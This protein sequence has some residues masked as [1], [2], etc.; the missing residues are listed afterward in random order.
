MHDDS[1]NRSN[2]VDRELLKTV[3]SLKDDVSE[4]KRADIDK[5]N[6]RKR[7][8][9]NEAS[10]SRLVSRDGEDISQPSEEEGSNDNP[11]LD[12]EDH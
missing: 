6:F 12:A 9:N 11:I 2:E 5:G 1:T 8:H 3:S 4:L 7:P 10:S